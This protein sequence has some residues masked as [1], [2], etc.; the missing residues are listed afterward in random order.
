MLMTTDPQLE[1]VE[2]PL[3]TVDFIQI[4][5]VCEEELKCAQRWNGPGVIE[6]L[7]RLPG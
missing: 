2:T 7:K 5:G 3:G 1:R 4:V 6:I